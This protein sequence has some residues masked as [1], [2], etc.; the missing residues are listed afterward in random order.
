MKADAACPGTY[1]YVDPDTN[2]H[3]PLSH[4]KIDCWAS[5]LVRAHFHQIYDILLMATKMKEDGSATLRKPP[6]HRLFDISGPA[7]SPVLQKR[8]AA[9]KAASTA[10]SAPV[11][12]FTLG[13]EVVELFRP[14]VP[15]PP[16]PIAL[17]APN[18]ISQQHLQSDSLLHPS[19]MPGNDANLVE[20]CN[21]YN[22]SSNILTKLQDNAYTDA[23]Q[24]Q[25]VQITDLKDMEFKLGEIASLRVAVERWS[26]PRVL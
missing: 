12:N 9:Q 26:V 10:S 3:L 4:E 23:S 2:E 6:N 18:I 21:Q 14:R 19:R 22:L 25:F 7:I 1:C 8:I 13:N 24:L 20:F 11:F 16:N 5:A 15:V 17:Q